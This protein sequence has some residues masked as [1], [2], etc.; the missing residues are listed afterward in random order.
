MGEIMNIQ[1]KVKYIAFAIAILVSKQ[2]LPAD[3]HDAVINDN[4]E[5]VARLIKKNPKCVNKVCTK[6][7]FKGFKPQHIAAYLDRYKIME[8]L[9]DYKEFKPESRV[10]N[11]SYEITPYK[12]HPTRN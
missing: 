5:K 6:G 7:K 8:M 1:N 4:Q 9:A 2:V 3:I 11:K 10:K 12:A